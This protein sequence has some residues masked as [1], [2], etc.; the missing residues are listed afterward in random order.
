[1]DPVAFADAQRMAHPDD[2]AYTVTLLPPVTQRHYMIRKN[3]KGDTCLV[4]SLFPMAVVGQ[5][6]VTATDESACAALSGLVRAIQPKVVLETGTHRGRSTKAIVS[7][8]LANTCVW[9]MEQTFQAAINAPG[10]CWTVDHYPF[11]DLDVVCTPAERPYVTQVL[12][13]TPAIYAEAPLCDLQ[14]IDFAYLDGDHTAVGLQ[15]DLD[16]VSAHRAPECWVV[17]DNTRDPG[18]PGVARVMAAVPWPRISL[19]TA[20]GTD[21]LWMTDS[22]ARSP[23]AE[24]ADR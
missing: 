5:P 12:G 11:V 4:D 15:A 21:V 14:G 16:F 18:F 24:T 3:G 8:L 7:A 10:H 13:V 17:V 23:R 22:V 6:N 1:M 20:C 19:P 2:F 9:L